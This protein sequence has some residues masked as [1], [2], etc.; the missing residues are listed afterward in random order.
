MSCVSFTGVSR[1]LTAKERQLVEKHVKALTGVELFFSGAA[2]G[3]DSWAA[4]CAIKHHPGAKHVVLVPTWQRGTCK[5]NRK[6]PAMLKTLVKAYEDEPELTV[7]R[8]PPTAR[9]PEGGL[10]R[11]DDMLAVNCTHGLAFPDRDAEVLRSGTW[12]TIRRMRR[13][14]RPVKLVPLDGG[15]VRVIK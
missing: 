1:K 10:L 15:R 5:H 2:D 9:T 3:V 14:D 13:L 11:R 7:K 12:A 4:I 6:L 8:C